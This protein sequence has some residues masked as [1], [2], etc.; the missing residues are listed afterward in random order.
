MNTYKLIYFIGIGGIG[1]SALARFFNEK[2]VQVYGYDRRPTP[3]TEKLSQ[4]GMNIIYEEDAHH[5][6]E[7]TD[8]FVYTPAIPLSNLILQAAQS[9][10]KPLQKRADV[11]EI[12][13]QQFECFAV[14]GTHGK[15]TI[16]TM[17]SYLLRATGYGCNAFLGGVSSNYGTNY[18]THERPLVVIEADEYDRSFLKL[19]PDLAILSAISAD[20]L[21]V[22]GN[23]EHVYQAFKDFINQIANEGTLIVHE[24]VPK[25]WDR[26]DL[27]VLS[28][29]LSNGVDFQALNIRAESGGF[30]FDI[31]DRGI[32]L[33]DFFMEMGGRHNVENILA[34]YAVSRLEGI[35]VEDIKRVMK[36]FKGV[37]RRYEYIIH[38]DDYVYIDDYA[39][40]PEELLKL[41]QGVK[42]AFPDQE[43]KIIFQPHL[44]SRTQSFYQEFGAS[45][46][47]ADEVILVPIYPARELPIEGVEVE[48]ILPF[49]NLKEDQVS[50]QT[51]NEVI[52]NLSFKK[53]Q[54]LIS[55]GA[56]DIDQIVLKIKEKFDRKE[57][58]EQEK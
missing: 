12:I 3:L 20:H 45:L 51:L 47:W 57:E 37:K 56:G 43:V 58:Y 13:S 49:I 35:E 27:K 40:H 2:G 55:A 41:L 46:S 48:M 9:S 23:E 4:E 17:T 21:D 34:A 39:H 38:E 52:E 29:G 53:G 1:M 50:V 16:T 15:T 7:G 32:L 42:K 10:G 5:I 18:W 44:Y 31:M 26:T 54:I 36:T 22:F 11:L 28:Y 30:R 14:A 6:P 19:H 8:L 25:V 24:Q 33:Q